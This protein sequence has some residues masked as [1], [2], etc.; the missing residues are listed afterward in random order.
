MC[1]S[2]RSVQLHVGAA[3]RHPWPLEKMEDDMT[4]TPSPIVLTVVEGLCAR[5]SAMLSYR[6]VALAERRRL[7]VVWSGDDACAGHFLD[8]FEPLAG[9][10]FIDG[11]EADMDGGIRCSS[12]AAHIIAHRCCTLLLH[13]PCTCRVIE[14]PLKCTR[15][16][17]S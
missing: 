14:V 11:A 16:T 1:G 17:S 5:L 12:V 6:L 2:G 15:L 3:P 10:E 13:M 7:L 4:D 8:H 9:V